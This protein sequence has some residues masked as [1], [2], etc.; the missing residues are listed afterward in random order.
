[1]QGSSLEVRAV[2]RVGPSKEAEAEAVAQVLLVLA[3]LEVMEGTAL[4]LLEA[5]Q[6]AIAERVRAEGAAGSRQR[7][8]E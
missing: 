5:T 1:V 6:S 3:P 4:A 8:P 7:H 2:P